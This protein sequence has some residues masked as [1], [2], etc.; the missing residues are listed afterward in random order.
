MSKMFCKEHAFI[1]VS[2]VVVVVVVVKDNWYTRSIKEEKGWKT[3]N[4]CIA[5]HEGLGMVT[6]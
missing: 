1:K 6:P 5:W 2:F 4:G 3:G